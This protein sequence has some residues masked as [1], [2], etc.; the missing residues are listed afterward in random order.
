MHFFRGEWKVGRA[1]HF[2]VLYFFDGIQQFSVFPEKRI[3][4]RFDKC[5]ITVP[6]SILQLFCF[7]GDF[8]GADGL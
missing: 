4:M 5:D 6:G 8:H 7:F 2:S 1:A 3:V